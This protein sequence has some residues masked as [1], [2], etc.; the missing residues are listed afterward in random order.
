MYAW[1]NMQAVMSLDSLATI[2]E[3]DQVLSLFTCHRW[4]SF[5]VR[6]FFLSVSTYFNIHSSKI[7]DSSFASLYKFIRN[8]AKHSLEHWKNFA[9]K[10]YKI[11][12]QT[13]S[14][15]YHSSLSLSLFI[16]NLEILRSFSFF[17]TY[18]SIHHFLYYFVR[19]SLS[20]ENK[21]IDSLLVSSYSNSRGRRRRKLTEEEHVG[22]C[23]CP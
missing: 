22:S 10:I 5:F 16:Q 19:K 15:L 14:H 20:I 6:S 8:W 12:T 9:P 21:R 11:T 4:N 23:V 13:F 17:S 7:L 1:R 3:H 18:F 2:G